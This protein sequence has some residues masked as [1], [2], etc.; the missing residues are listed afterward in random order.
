MNA[1]KAASQTLGLKLRFIEVR[2]ASEFK[3]AF[4][5]VVQEQK[6]ALLILID[7]PYRKSNPHVLM[8]QSTKHRPHF[9]APGALDVPTNGRILA[10][11]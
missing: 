4:D 1:A 7:C 10:Q 11:R 6:G 8:V 5:A 3:P 9:D 2:A